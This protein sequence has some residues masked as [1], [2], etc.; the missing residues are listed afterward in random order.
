[1]NKKEFY[2]KKFLLAFIFFAGFN[3]GASHN[4]EQDR[5]FCG[6][7]VELPYCNGY[8]P[9]HT[10]AALT[11]QKSWRK[12]HN[13]N[14]QQYNDYRPAGVVVHDN[15]IQTRGSVYRNFST[16]FPRADLS[17]SDDSKTKAG[18]AAIVCCLL[19][20][21]S[22]GFGFGYAPHTYRVYNEG[23]DAI[24]LYYRP[25][26]SRQ[27]CH[28]NSDGKRS[29]TTVET[30]CVKYVSPGRHAKI[31]NR[32]S[33]TKLCAEKASFVSSFNYECATHKGLEKNYNWCVDDNLSFGRCHDAQDSGS[34]NSSTRVRQLSDK[35]EHVA[36][37]LRG[38]NVLEKFQNKSSFLEQYESGRK[39]LDQT[40]K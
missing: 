6:N 23:S 20:G 24:D 9:R 28:T 13:H 26:C 8:Q 38:S 21:A 1:M 2:M 12:H 34:T 7:G 3:L 15:N 27:S 11:L 19:V 40:K 37:Y 36:N 10:A 4:Y 29:C 33:L 39:F 18:C 5:S 32:G 35:H 17:F 25:G 16:N 31:Y 22:F 30:D 14:H